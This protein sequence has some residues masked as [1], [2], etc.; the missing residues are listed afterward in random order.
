MEFVISQIRLIFKLVNRRKTQSYNRKNFDE[1]IVFNCL[2]K[3]Y[4]KIKLKN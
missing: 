1:Y 2:K 3:N 4:I